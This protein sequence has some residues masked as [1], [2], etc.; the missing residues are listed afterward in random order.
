MKE[1]ELKLTLA[2]E[3][4]DAFRGDALL[5]QLSLE[6][7]AAHT[8]HLDN[9][10]FDTPDLLLNKSHAALR[11]RKTPNHYVQTLKNKGQAIAGLHQRGEWETPLTVTAGEAPQLDWAA[12]PEDARPSQAI[13]DRIEPLFKTDFERTTWMIPHKQSEIELVLDQ[14]QISRG[15]RHTPLCEVELELKSGNPEDLFDFALTLAQK[16]PLVPCDVNKAERGYQLLNSQLSFFEPYECREDDL[17]VNALISDSLSRISRRWDDFI[18]SRN[19]WLL[20]VIQRQVRGLLAVM[21]ALGLEQSIRS[22]WNQVSEQ[23]DQIIS[24]ASLPVGLFVDRNNNS[25]GLS[26]RILKLLHGDVESRLK[27]LVDS[28]ELGQ[29]MLKLGLYLYQQPSAAFAAEPV[30]NN[31]QEQMQRIKQ[32]DPSNLDDQLGSLPLLQAQAYLYNRLNHPCYPALNAYVDQL[33]IVAGMRRAEQMLPS[34]QDG[35]SRAKLASWTRRLT[36]E[37]R[38]LHDIHKPLQSC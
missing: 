19:W 17:N 29:A 31:T 5:G 30:I 27:H 20:V 7:A 16:Y 13:R 32:L 21:D 6:D 9:Q 34:L 4:M 37:L 2:S 38:A 3:A 25:R 11:I 22:S 18:Y 10:Y 35:D 23:F 15:D 14:G 8:E 36:V 28:N 26:Q 1:I 12:L 33:L 24:P